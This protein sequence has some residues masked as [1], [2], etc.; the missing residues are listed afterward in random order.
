MRVADVMNV[1]ACEL[2]KPQWRLPTAYSGAFFRHNCTTW[3]GG[4]FMKVYAQGDVVLVQVEDIE[5]QPKTMVVPVGPAV[6]LAEGERSGHRHAF[7]GGATLFRDEALARGVPSEL[8][9]GHVKI[10]PAGAVLEHGTGPGVKGDHDPITVPA[11][12]YVACRQREYVSGRPGVCRGIHLYDAQ[13]RR[14]ED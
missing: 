7:Y 5:L 9:I 1:A 10:A 8:Y 11:G 4:R 3:Q 12:T 14:V 13:F 2:D 6:V